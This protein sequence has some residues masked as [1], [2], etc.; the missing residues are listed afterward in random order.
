MLENNVSIMIFKQVIDTVINICNIINKK[1]L[2]KGSQ[3][4][5]D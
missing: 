1:S 5:T 3:D 2:I 4:Q